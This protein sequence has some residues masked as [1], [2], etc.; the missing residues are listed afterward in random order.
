M[1]AE[2][3]EKKVIKGKSAHAD[4]NEK[5]TAS[6][7]HTSETENT[8][9]KKKTGSGASSTSKKSSTINAAKARSA[10]K[11]EGD[12]THIKM[13]LR[14]YDKDALRC[15]L[16]HVLNTLKSTGSVVQ[17]VIRMPVRRKLL[18]VNRGPHIDK[19]SRE[20][21]ELKT[22]KCTIYVTPNSQTMDVLRVLCL[23]SAV[24]VTLR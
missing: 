9:S 5:K 6:A 22:H 10:I 2:N 24:G 7:T 23:P 18:T 12:K 14:S 16:Q 15:G 17:A 13:I 4:N 20:Q 3:Q 21:F 8:T 11:L 19:T 1:N